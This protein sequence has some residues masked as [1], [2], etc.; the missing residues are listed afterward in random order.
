MHEQRLPFVGSFQ[1]LRGG[2]GFDA[3]EIVVGLIFFGGGE[4]GA[5]AAEEEG[6]VVSHGDAVCLFVRAVERIVARG[7]LQ[8]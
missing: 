2:I 3:E 5:A 7:R 8:C 4:E 1:F 6:D